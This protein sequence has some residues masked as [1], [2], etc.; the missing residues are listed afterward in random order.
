MAP[1]VT[2]VIQSHR[3]HFL[4][5]ALASVLAQTVQDVQIVV[6]YCEENWP[7]KF[8]EPAAIARGE[9]IVPLCD[10]DL[11]APTF[12]EECLKVAEKGDMIYTDRLVFFDGDDPAQGIRV[13]QMGDAFTLETAGPK[14]YYFTQFPPS[15]FQAGASLPM[16]CMIRKSWWDELLGYDPQMPHA[17]TELWYRSAAHDPPA[18]FLYVPRPLFLYRMHPE[19]YSQTHPSILG[20]MR[21]FH[22]KHF[23]AFGML[24]DEAIPLDDAKENWY[25]QIVPE[26]ERAEHPAARI[27]AGVGGG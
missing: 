16:T 23:S 22:R 19:Q 21:A 17:D 5:G 18:R 14:G 7:T 12:L 20:A 27:A 26:A 11:L 4:P 6:Q 25:C 9:F 13:R 1:R 15:T 24:F 3:A 8:N 2:V 10:D